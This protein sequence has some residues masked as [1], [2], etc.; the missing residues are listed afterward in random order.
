LDASSL[1]LFGSTLDSRIAYAGKDL[2]SFLLL[3]WVAGITFMLLVTVSVLQ[4]RE[5]AHPKLLGQVIRPQEP[6]PDLLGNLLN[7]SVA[8][9][10]KRMTLSI[11][12]YAALLTLHVHIPIQLISASNLLQ[13]A[14]FLRL[15]FSYVLMSQ[16]QIPLELLFFHLCMLGILEKNKNSIGELQHH[17][18]KLLGRILGLTGVLLPRVVE[19]FR[20]VG[21]RPIFDRRRI[22]P[23][24][25]SLAKADERDRERLLA[26]KAL[27]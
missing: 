10:A 5:V 13:R 4:L 3:H 7:E 15:K 11:I 27:N 20:L 19:E 21:S 26:S 6:Q 22:D 9:H 14:P 18:F 23:F 25:L 16:L 24:W 2:F 12:I 1:S 17:W 8:T